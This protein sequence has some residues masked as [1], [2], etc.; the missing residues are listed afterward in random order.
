MRDDFNSAAAMLRM[1]GAAIHGCPA[2]HAER[3]A[4][5]VVKLGRL[6]QENP[7][8]RGAVVE[9][10]GRERADEDALSLRVR[11]LS[12][13]VVRALADLLKAVEPLAQTATSAVNQFRPVPVRRAKPSTVAEIA[14]VIR[15]GGTIEFSGPEVILVVNDF[16]AKARSV[17]E[18]LA[19]SD[20][21][22]VDVLAALDVFDELKR[23]AEALVEIEELMVRASIGRLVVRIRRYVAVW[24][25]RLDGT[26]PTGDVKTNGIEH[27]LPFFVESVAAKLEEGVA[28]LYALHRVRVLFE[29]FDRKMLRERLADAEGVGHERERILQ[30]AMDRFLFHDGYYPVT[31]TEA[32]GGNLDTL[33]LREAERSGLPPLLIELKQ[34]TAFAEPSKATRAGVEAAIAAARGQVERYRGHVATRPAWAGTIPVIVVV[35]TCAEDLS[36]IEG[37]GVVLIDLSAV[38]PSGKLPAKPASLAE[39]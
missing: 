11:D 24:E 19:D 20:D 33:V 34:V 9:M 3:R 23:K 38:P 6:V 15:G 10:V 31:H 12:T 21:E 5:Y 4:A 29:H 28:R 7:L 36:D 17:L 16:T 27:D 37:P 30:R 32:S 25:G 39:A 2:K 35:H 14:R 1:L 18:P 13:E 26:Y 8:V 22:V